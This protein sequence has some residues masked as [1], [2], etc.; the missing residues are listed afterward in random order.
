MEFGVDTNIIAR[1]ISEDDRPWL[2]LSLSDDKFHKDTDVDFFYEHGTVCNVYEDEAGPV[3]AVRGSKVL[4]LDIQFLANNNNRRNAHI[5]L[6]GFPQLAKQAK[7]NGFK[8]IIFNSTSPELIAFC[9]KYLGFEK[10][11]NELRR[12]L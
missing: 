8:E 5:M 7:E 1:P 3:L 2:E 12:L 4:R 9:E 10:S 11:G 6:H